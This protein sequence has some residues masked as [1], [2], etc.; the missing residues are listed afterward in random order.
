MLASASHAATAS[1]SPSSTEAA[2][3][4]ASCPW[5]TRPRRGS[6]ST[7]IPSTGPARAEK[8]RAWFFR[9]RDKDFSFTDCTSFVV[10]KE[11]RLRSALTCDRH[12][13]QAGFEML[14]RVGS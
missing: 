2:Q 8:A 14:P 12:F 4:F 7:R 13:R 1:V 6:R 3:P 5:K 10:M 9:Y 11:R